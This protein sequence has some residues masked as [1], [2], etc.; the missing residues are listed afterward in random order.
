[1]EKDRAD[2][3]GIIISALCLVHC[4]A[5]PFVVY[6]L[7]V[8]ARSF[9]HPLF[10]IGVALFVLPVGLWAFFRGF[11]QHKSYLVLGLGIVGMSIVALAAFIPHE[12]LHQVGHL[13]WTLIGSV[14]LVIGHWLN[15]RSIHQHCAC[16]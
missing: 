13:E 2:I 5:T 7:P 6:S 9:H 1:M 14:F 8:L 10:H 16:H 3:A 12:W 11:R 4:I 15:R